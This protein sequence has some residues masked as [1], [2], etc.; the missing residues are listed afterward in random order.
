MGGSLLRH[1][2]WSRL[3]TANASGGRTAHRRGAF[4]PRAVTTMWR[5]WMTSVLL[6]SAGDITCYA[7]K[8]VLM[9]WNSVLP[10]F[11]NHQQV[12]KC[13]TIKEVEIEKDHPFTISG[14][15][16]IPV[17]AMHADLSV[18]GFRIDNFAYMTDVKIIEDSEMQ[19]LMDWTYWCWMPCALNPMSRI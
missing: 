7:Y 5:D 2:L 9:P 19:K 3:Q 10:M 17:E 13:P 15:K 16:V 11:W 18:L 6:F 1:W 14:K 4:Y 8:R 12:P